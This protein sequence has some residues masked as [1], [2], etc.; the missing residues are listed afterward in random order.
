MNTTGESIQSQT[1]QTVGR[2]ELAIRKWL[3]TNRRQLH[4]WKTHADG[5]RRLTQLS[6]RELADIGIDRIDAMQE[7]AKPFWKA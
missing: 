6:D 3:E 1:A 5:R 2:L 4:Q 7:A